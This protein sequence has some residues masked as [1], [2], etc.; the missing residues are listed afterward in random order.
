[1]IRAICPRRKR[2]RGGGRPAGRGSRPFAAAA[3][4]TGCGG[5][6]GKNS[7]PGRGKKFHIQSDLFPAL[8]SGR[9]RDL[10]SKYHAHGQGQRAWNGRY[11]IRRWRCHRR[12]SRRWRRCGTRWGAW[13]WGGEGGVRGHAGSPRRGGDA[14]AGGS[15]GGGC[16][17]PASS[18][19]R[20]PR[21]SSANRARLE[22][23]RSPGGRLR[24]R[25]MEPAAAAPHSA[26]NPVP[27]VAGTR[28]NRPRGAVH[29]EWLVTNGLGG[30]ASGTI[31]GC[32]THRSPRT[33]H[34]RARRARADRDA[35][36]PGGGDRGAGGAAR[37]ARRA[38]ST[39]RLSGELPGSSTCGG[40]RLR[41]LVPEWEYALPRGAALSPAHPRSQGEPRSSWSTG[42]PD[43]TSF[44][45]R[46]RP[47]P[48]YRAHDAR[49]TPREPTPPVGVT[50]RRPT[51]SRCGSKS[52]S[53]PLRFRLLLERYPSPFVEP[54][55]P[56]SRSCST[57]IEGKAGGMTASEVQA[58]PGVLPVRASARA[59]RSLGRQHP[60]L[61]VPRP[62]AGGG[63]R[64]GAAAGAPPRW[65]ARRRRRGPAPRRGWCWRGSN[66]HRPGAAPRTRRG[67]APWGRTAGR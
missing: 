65:S 42:T 26:A 33:V 46:L 9:H 66:H 62:R 56:L 13:R 27:G 29:R 28:P 64:P 59:R 34:P 67:R 18:N 12:R 31:A 20:L 6:S 47:F 45:L 49:M 38:R 2:P 50:L 10:F 21:S 44:S 3:R 51:E 16:S 15:G 8:G 60:G 7:G 54:L 57:R 36:P 41:G 43:N 4:R 24:P 1:M 11:I 52:T 23:S 61:G 37:E 14:H 19:V 40:F 39:R 53:R 55:R 17:P 63:V 22:A 35:G 5:R 30:Y 32:D 25:L 48:V 58:R